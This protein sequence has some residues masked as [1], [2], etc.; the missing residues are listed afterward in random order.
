MSWGRPYRPSRSPA[1]LWVRNL[2][3][4]RVPVRQY[5]GCFRN[6][7]DFGWILECVAALNLE[8]YN[9]QNVDRGVRIRRCL[10]HA[11]VCRHLTV[12][13]SALHVSPGPDGVAC[14]I[15]DALSIGEDSAIYSMVRDVGR[16]AWAS[17][18]RGVVPGVMT[19]L[20]YDRM[21]V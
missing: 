16:T 12:N 7:L 6:P 8:R 18:A 10:D 15:S 5:Y 14:R 2:F 9:G 17:F 21:P 3:C 4:C 11:I 13:E 19:N 20:R 1:P